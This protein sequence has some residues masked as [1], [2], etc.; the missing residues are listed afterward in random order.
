[1]EIK[2][3][4]KTKNTNIYIKIGLIVFLFVILIIPISMTIS[5]IEER[6]SLQQNVFRE[7]GD[8]WGKEQ[9][10]VSPVICVPYS[11][12]EV[13][14]D[15]KQTINH[16]LYITPETIQ[17]NSDV[18][19]EI[20]KKGIFNCI[21]YQSDVEIKGNFKTNIQDIQNIQWDQ[22]TIIT[23]I[24]DPTRI[25]KKV[26]MNWDGK[27]IESNPSTKYT[28]FVQNGIHQNIA[29][30]PN[31][32]YQ[33]AMKINLNGSNSISY[34]PTGKENNIFT[35][36]NWPSP[37]FFGTN[38]PIKKEISDKGFTANWSTS[39]FNRSFPQS[40]SDDKFNMKLLSNEYFGVKL[41]ETANHYQQNTRTVKYSFLIIGLSFLVYFLF[42]ILF[43][44]NV[45]ILQYLLIGASLA[46]FYVLLLSFSEQVGFRNAYII[47]FIATLSLILF[48]S[49]NIFQQW[50]PVGIL[51]TLMTILYAYIYVLLMLEDYSLLVG[52]IGLFFILFTIMYI[53]RK[54]NWFEVGKG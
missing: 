39:E 19:S 25:N 50:K 13:V 47:S 44:I 34:T 22:A 8:S 21:V 12:I 36:C 31:K 27:D 28:N 24:T 23:G 2:S 16:L 41:I 46:L 32:S 51:A 9:T 54:T 5:L 6:Q 40:W 3:L 43:K 11:T 1:M 45:H 10:I 14:N 30:E 26:T 42:E 29:I 4:E 53:T 17:V 18:N 38:L 48:Y 52:S 20:R 15:K 35:K 37:S 7:I 33:F 49:K